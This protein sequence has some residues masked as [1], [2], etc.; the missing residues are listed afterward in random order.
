VEQCGVGRFFFSTERDKK[1][2][3]EEFKV[4]STIT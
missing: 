3:F 1:E 4:D 2:I